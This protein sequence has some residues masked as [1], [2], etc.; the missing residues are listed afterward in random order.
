MR[1]RSDPVDPVASV[2]RARD[3]A[4]PVV[5]QSARDA[6]GA[7]VAFSAERQ[8]LKHQPVVGDLLLVRQAEDARALLRESLH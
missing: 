4:E 2:L 8:R 5:L 1:K 7:T 6:G 3:A